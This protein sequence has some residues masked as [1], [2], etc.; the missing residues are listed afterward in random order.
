MRRFTGNPVCG[1]TPPVRFLLTTRNEG[2]R[3][4]QLVTVLRELVAAPNW[5]ALTIC[6]INPDH[7]ELDGST[8]CTLNEA[9]AEVLSG[10]GRGRVF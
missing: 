9:L 5:V 7:A 1:T 6:E 10:S 4:T 2:L 3:F 8:L